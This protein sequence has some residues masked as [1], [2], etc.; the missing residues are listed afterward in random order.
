MEPTLIE[1]LSAGMLNAENFQNTKDEGV[2]V[3]ESIIIRCSQHD[4]YE[5]W[6]NF[7]NLPQTLTIFREVKITGPQQSHW[8]LVTPEGKT[9]EWEAETV[10]DKVD[11]MISWHGLPNAIVKFSGTIRFLHFAEGETELRVTI[12]YPSPKENLIEQVTQLFGIDPTQ[13]VRNELQK[14]K[15]L[16]EAN[17][18]TEKPSSY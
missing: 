10:I 15:R 14:F 18:I 11:D 3:D 16:M 4:L 1:E 7:Q 9:I 17:S 5:F 6:H 2:R 8:V 13:F 12:E